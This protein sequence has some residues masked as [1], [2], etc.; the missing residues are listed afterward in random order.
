MNQVMSMKTHM[1][2]SA[3]EATEWPPLL[4][5][6][7]AAKMTGLSD[8]YIHKLRKAGVIKSYK[9]LGGTHRYYRDNLKEHFGL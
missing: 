1:P 7:Q 5:V 8:K 3:V 9:L 2:Q 6:T 4:T